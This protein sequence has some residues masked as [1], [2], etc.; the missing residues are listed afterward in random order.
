MNLS[1]PLRSFRGGMIL[2]TWKCTHTSNIGCKGSK[3][4]KGSRTRQVHTHT[5]T[6][7]FQISVARVARVAELDSYTHGR[8]SVRYR[9]PLTWN[10]LPSEVRSITNIDSFKNKLKTCKLENISYDKETA[11]GT[12]RN[13][14]YF[15]F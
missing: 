11:V 8:N 10:N 12:N 4:S 1:F 13:S 6:H 7:T 3:S 5:H 15:Y 14:D 2:R 9:G